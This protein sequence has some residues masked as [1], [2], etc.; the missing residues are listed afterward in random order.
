MCVHNLTASGSSL[1]CSVCCV[2]PVLRGHPFSNHLVSQLTSKL[3][4]GW[5]VAQHHDRLARSPELKP[6]ALGLRAWGWRL[7]GLSYEGLMNGFWHWAGDVRTHKHREYLRGKMGRT[8][9]QIETIHFRSSCT[10]KFGSP[11]GSLRHADKYRTECKHTP[12]NIIMWN[13]LEPSP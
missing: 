11:E 12:P 4:E 13:P 7:T 3:M 8:V 2:T 1:T 10:Q 9:G 6:L 5:P